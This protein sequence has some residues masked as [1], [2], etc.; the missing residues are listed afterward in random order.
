MTIDEAL[1]YL[2]RDDASIRFFS[3][4]DYEAFV[5]LKKYAKSQQQPCEDCISREALLDNLE[6]PMNWTDS[7][8][9]IQEQRDYEGFIE[10]VKSMPSITPSYNSIKTELKPCEDCVSRDA[11]EKITWEEPSYDDALNVLTEVRDKVRALPSVEPQR[12]NG[13]WIIDD[14]FEH[15]NARCN[16]CGNIIDSRLLKWYPQRYA[17][18]SSCGAKMKEGGNDET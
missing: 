2:E 16:K 7:E 4:Q 1:L 8:A 6:E 11:V 5:T 18:C 17:Y 10:L 13:E 12:P 3:P 14:D 15:H 9:E